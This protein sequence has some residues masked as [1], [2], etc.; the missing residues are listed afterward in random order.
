MQL[1]VTPFHFEE[2]IKKGYSLDQI[3]LLKLIENQFDITLLCE[4][5]MKIAALYQSLERKGL[6]TNDDCITLIGQTLLDF[7]HTE[8]TTKL[9]KRK[10]ANTEFEEWWGTYPGT[11]TFTY[12]DKPFVGSRSLRQD[13]VNCRLKFDKILIEGDYTA[14]QLILALAYDVLQKKENSIRSNTNK[15]TF[16]QNSL[17]YLNQ[18]SYEP[19]I[20]LIQDGTKI[21]EATKIIGGTDI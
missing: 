17:T 8:E 1:Q 4:N 9:I 14:K 15:L 3:Y 13:K 16:M 11:D 10:P 20:E 19:F 18:R 6:I 2:F 12:K 21:I 7:M 5:S